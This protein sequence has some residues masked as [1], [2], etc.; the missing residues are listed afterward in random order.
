MART[1]LLALFVAGLYLATR[2]RALRIDGT[3]GRLANLSL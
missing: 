2:R 3:S 1:R